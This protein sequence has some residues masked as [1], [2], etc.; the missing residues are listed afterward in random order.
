MQHHYNSTSLLTRPKKV[1]EI[2][3]PDLV[4][5]PARLDLYDLPPIELANGRDRQV[6]LT[7]HPKVGSPSIDRFLAAH[8]NLAVLLSGRKFTVQRPRPQVQ[9][10]Y[11]DQPLDARSIRNLPG[12][13]AVR[14]NQWD[15]L[16]DLGWLDPGL[17]HLGG[18]DVTF[19]TLAAMDRFERLETLWYASNSITGSLPRAFAGLTSLRRIHLERVRLRT[20]GPLASLTRIEEA[21]LSDLALED[22]T[23]LSAWSR[24]RRLALSSRGTLDGIENFPDLEHL[25]LENVKCPPI[26]A[27]AKLPR[28]RHLEIKTVKGPSDLIQ[29]L[30]KL[31]GLRRLWIQSD[32]ANRFPSASLFTPMKRLE[33]LHIGFS[34]ILDGRVSKFGA[35]EKLQRFWLGGVYRRAEVDRLRAALPHCTTLDVDVDD[36]SDSRPVLQRRGLV[37]YARDE[38][39]DT[40]SIFQ[41]LS[42][43][44]DR[45]NHDVEKLIKAAVKRKDPALAKR[46][47]FDSESDKFC[48]VARTEESIRQVA[49]VINALVEDRGD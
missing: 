24:L 12:L 18:Y 31:T 15:G 42:A 20:A 7:Q 33:E 34:Q 8:P 39:E 22:L 49:D 46:L 1:R 11:S 30:P 35:L 27:L 21:A 10:L 16:V 28:L 4:L 5:S 29:T 23:S 9:A 19:K 47:L 44:F 43:D 13:K 48:V 26:A 3:L 45:N 37:E 40:W 25:T 38:G 32:T 36:S 2:A 41:N 17:A 6:V 14:F